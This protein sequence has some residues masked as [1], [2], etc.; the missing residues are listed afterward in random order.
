MIF[1]EHSK[2][3]DIARANETITLDRAPRQQWNNKSVDRY[4]DEKQNDLVTHKM[5]KTLS[6]LGPLKKKEEE[7]PETSKRL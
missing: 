3:R 7:N 2:K 5:A 6:A 1:N 4:R